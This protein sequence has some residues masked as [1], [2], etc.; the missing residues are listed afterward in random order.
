MPS[1]PRQ[2]HL[3]LT[4]DVASLE[5]HA[6]EGMGENTLNALAFPTSAISG[7]VPADGVRSPWS[8]PEDLVLSLNFVAHR[9]WDPVKR[10]ESRHG[11]PADVLGRIACRE[12]T[13]SPWAT[14]ALNR[15]AAVDELV[16]P[17]PL[18]RAGR[19]LLAVA[20]AS[21][22]FPCTP[23]LGRGSARARRP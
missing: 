23:T 18:A 14:C 20:H 3:A 22:Q 9:L 6:S 8:A 13:Q 4:D 1:R 7:L 16:D 10:S 15:A 11:M 5:H 21:L 2:D 17:E 19:Y 12:P